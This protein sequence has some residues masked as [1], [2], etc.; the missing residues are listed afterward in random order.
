[1]PSYL[2]EAQERDIRQ[3]V[4]DRA[5]RNHVPQPYPGKMIVFRAMERDQFEAH[6]TDPKFGWG[7]LAVEGVEVHDVPGDHIGILKEP[8]VQVM[9]AKLR[10]CLEQAQVDNLGVGH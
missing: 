7:D 1:L 2:Q 6:D 3:Q 9:A 4:R 5:V 10:A 8:H